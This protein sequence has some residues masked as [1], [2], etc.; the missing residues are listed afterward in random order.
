MGTVVRGVWLSM[1][2][3]LIQL[4]VWMDITIQLI[5]C[6]VVNL[7]MRIIERVHVVSDLCCVS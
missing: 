3:G 7:L 6:D 1:H 2:V 4:H 5:V